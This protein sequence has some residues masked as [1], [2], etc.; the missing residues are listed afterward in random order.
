MSAITL[1]CSLTVPAN[2]KGALSPHLDEQLL[3]WFSPDDVATGRSLFELGRQNNVFWGR[4]AII[5][6][7]IHPGGNAN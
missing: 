3:C 1:L 7:T 4:F 6:F 2:L 5:F